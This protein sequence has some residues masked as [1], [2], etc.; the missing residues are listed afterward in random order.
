M[1]RGISRQSWT[2][3]CLFACGLFLL[4]F[5][6]VGVS[7]DK[8]KSK[9]KATPKPPPQAIVAFID[10]DRLPLGAFLETELFEEEGLTWV[11]RN[12]IDRVLAEQKLQ[13]LFS[14]EAVDE[15]AKISRL[16][17]A[18]LLILL[19]TGK[20]DELETAEIAVAEVSRGVRLVSRTIPLTS[21]PAADVQTLLSIV[22]EGIAK[23]QHE[24]EAIYAV[25]PFLSK[26]LLFEHHDL[27][28]TYARLIEQQ[29]LE[30]PQI[31][32]VEFA[33]A[34]A[35]MRERSL[36]V[37]G[38]KIRRLL[39]HYLLGEYRNERKDEERRVTITL[40][41]KH[42]EQER[43]RVKKSVHPDDAA[44][45]LRQTVADVVERQTGKPPATPD[46]KREAEQLLSR[47][48]EYLTLGDYEDAAALA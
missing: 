13:L 16:L 43:T 11:D 21:D 26:D 9:P 15:R 48:K 22:R 24:I 42:G 6:G 33:E 20:K 4:L 19:R 10:F 2:I 39:P 36:A 29:L 27:R 45:F 25:P 34:E 46:P 41:H 32:V 7:Q 23:Q 12:E 8:V 28:K 37:A 1:Q 3:A 44:L 31:L 38:Q 5:A 35:L 14:P 30:Q 40:T 17:K 18:D 47:A